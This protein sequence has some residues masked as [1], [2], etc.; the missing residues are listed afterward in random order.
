M[1]FD[2]TEKEMIRNQLAAIYREAVGAVHPANVMPRYIS[3]K[4]DRLQLGEHLFRSGNFKQIFV[5]GAGKASAEMAA[6]CENVLGERITDGIVAV[7]DYPVM[8]PRSI[9]PFS[10]GHPVPDTNSIIAADE[11]LKLVDHIEKNDLLIFLLSGGASSLMTDLPPFCSLAELNQFY[12]VLVNSGAT[13]NEINCVR[14]HLSV[15]KGGNLAKRCK[16][17]L[18]SFIISDVPGNDLS[19]VGS[20][21]TVA[22][23]STFAQAMEIINRYSLNKETPATIL[24]HLQ[25][26][27]NGLVPENPR[28]SDD[29]FRNT[30][31]II[32]ADIHRAMDAAATKAAELGYEVVVEKKLM[33]GNTMREA[34]SLVDRL[35]ALP[36]SSKQCVVLGGETSLKV[37][38]SGKGGRNQHFALSC[39]RELWNTPH[40]S[41][42]AAGTDGNDGNTNA[43]GAFADQIAGSRAQTL[44]TD[45]GGY[46]DQFDS[47]SFFEK[48]DSLFIPGFSGTNVM[49]LVIA[50]ISPPA[51]F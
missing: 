38:G 28:D 39:L 10:A 30:T 18:M 25:K 26:G 7:K 44:N 1:T 40:I 32:V 41:L 6:V 45:P 3:L 16:G 22:D 48:T 46:L 29:C 31:N 27:V 51:Q 2:Q 20:G 11:L 50:V 4:N 13:I 15:I 19:V 12:G 36:R 21:P 47:Y 37:E 33:T 34:A 42:L 17:T 5:A 43:A 8:I 24:Q 49:D 14:K 35:S 9:R 23:N